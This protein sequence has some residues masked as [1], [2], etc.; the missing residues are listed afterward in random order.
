MSLLVLLAA[1]CTSDIVE[2]GGGGGPDV[3]N[4]S[5]P[6]SAPTP[7]E[8][9][10]A[11]TLA[12]TEVPPTE[13]PVSPPTEEPPATAVPASDL[14]SSA[15]DGLGGI[16]NLGPLASFTIFSTINRYAIGEGPE[17]NVDAAPAVV[18]SSIVSHDVASDSIRL[19]Y[20]R[21]G[22]AVADYSE[23]ITGDVGYMMGSDSRFG[24]G[25]DSDIASDRVAS[26]RKQ[27]RLVN[28]H[29]LLREAVDH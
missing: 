5:A 13:I 7:T 26:T 18:L 27:Q 3:S 8:V 10:P 22:E 4:T 12:Q 23:I 19:D 24:I 2:D 20:S 1:G 16:A 21:A 11:A 25:A 29:L 6:T 17:P 15:I 28:P 9:G 14:L